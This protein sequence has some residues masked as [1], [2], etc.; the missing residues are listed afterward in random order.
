MEIL[1]QQF[2]IIT[3]NLAHKVSHPVIDSL[4]LFV[5]CTISATL[6][7]IASAS[8]IFQFLSHFLCHL[9]KTRGEVRNPIQ[10]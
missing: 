5:I 9:N 1:I 4:F 2:E 3:F 7:V 6:L 10:S 8:A